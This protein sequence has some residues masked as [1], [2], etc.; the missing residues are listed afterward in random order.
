MTLTSSHYLT[1][2]VPYVHLL[3]EYGPELD[4]SLP[5]QVDIKFLAH[6]VLSET[7]PQFNFRELPHHPMETITPVILNGP[8]RRNPVD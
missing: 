5:P 1:V 2:N 7:L 6:C 4:I 8:T 3:P